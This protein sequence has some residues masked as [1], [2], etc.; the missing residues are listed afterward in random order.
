MPRLR[1]IALALA[2]ACV[3]FAA[4]PSEGAAIEFTA[5]D[6]PDVV[7]GSDLWRYDYVVSGVI[8]DAFQAFTVY[9]D[10]ANY[11]DLSGPA[12]A[13]ASWLVDVFQPDVIFGTPVDGAFFAQALVDGAPLT[14]PFSVDFVFLGSGAPGAQP[15]DLSAFDAQ[16]NFIDIIETGRVRD[17][18]SVPEPS[19]L[20]LAGAGLT[21]AI[22]RRRS[23]AIQRT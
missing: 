4:S 2:F 6:L 22:R 8:F 1:Q 18:S 23:N 10:P 11:S 5:T 19:L 17:A 9:F 13:N 3:S 14:A 15:Y 16:G 20:L 21:A 12:T 7:A